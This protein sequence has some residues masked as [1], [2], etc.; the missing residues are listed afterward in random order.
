[1]AGSAAIV[2]TAAE[3]VVEAHALPS[4]QGANSWRWLGLRLDHLSQVRRSG[5]LALNE[6]FR[7]EQMN[8]IFAKFHLER[9]GGSPLP[10]PAV[11]HRF[12]GAERGDPHDHP[13][14]FTTH[15]LSGGYVEEI[16]TCEASGVWIRTT[17]ARLPGTAHHVPATRI[18]R[19]VDL[20]TPECWTMILPG[21]WE[22]E[23]RFWRFPVEGG[24]L[25][26][27]WHETDFHEWNGL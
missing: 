16:Y 26:R 3:A 4:R 17:I 7:L 2:G 27:A 11:F 15:I 13:W 8:D 25:S 18:H 21:P 24:A 19:I 9:E 10:F 1:M 20:L 12:S 23:S 14:G 5:V 22:R 6:P